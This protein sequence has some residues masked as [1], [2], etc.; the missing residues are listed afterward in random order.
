MV[1]FQKT[2][3]ERREGHFEKRFSGELKDL[4]KG[5]LMLEEREFYLEQH[6]IK[7]NDY[8]TYT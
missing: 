2:G 5:R 4:I 1:A 3:T 6:P 7:G 8:Y